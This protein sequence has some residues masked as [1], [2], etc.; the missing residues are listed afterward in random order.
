LEEEGYCPEQ[1]GDVLPGTK[2]SDERSAAQIVSEAE[3]LKRGAW[4]FAEVIMMPRDGDAHMRKITPPRAM[5]GTVKVRL[6]SSSWVLIQN[7]KP[8]TSSASICPRN[9]GARK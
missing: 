1:A 4:Q 2:E 6:H 8:T 9:S 3:R 5:T 7:P